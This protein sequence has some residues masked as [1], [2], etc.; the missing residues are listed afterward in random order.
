[1]IDSPQY[2][3]DYT[4]KRFQFFLGSLDGQFLVSTLPLL[5]YG[6]IG[7]VCLNDAKSTRTKNRFK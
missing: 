1:M 2:N 3:V 6:Q 7:M 5:A 4:L